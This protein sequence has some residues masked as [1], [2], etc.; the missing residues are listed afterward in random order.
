MANQY[1]INLGEVYRTGEAL[2]RSRQSREQNALIMDW[3]KQDRKK[4]EQQATAQQKRQNMLASLRAKAVSGDQQAQKQLV[5]MDPAE[6]T[7]FATAVKQMDENQRQ[8][9]QQNIEQIGQMS[10]YIANSENPE[11]AYQYVRQNVN[12]EVSQRMP[13]QYDPQFIDYSLARAQEMDEILK[14][15]EV[16]EF[17]GEDV[18]FKGGREIDRTESSDIVEQ[19]VKDSAKQAAP[20]VK[21][22]DINA[23]YRQSAELLGGVF[24]QQGNLQTL[25]PDARSNVQ[26]I[27]TEAAKLFQSGEAK[28]HSEAVTKAARKLGIKVKNLGANT[29]AL[30]DDDLL[31]RY[32]GN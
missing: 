13:E 29:N 11:Q 22:S 2:S 10:A 25:D 6:A 14:N 18:M 19:R 4:A 17:G 9:T 26:A 3:K 23:I 24:D 12:P 20:E 7:E 5:A 28:N 30:S 15:P 16:I 21:A 32:R 31:N 27:S 1:G 8:A